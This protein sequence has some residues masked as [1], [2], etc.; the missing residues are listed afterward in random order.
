VPV[1]KLLVVTARGGSAG[2]DVPVPERLTVWGLPLP[3]SLILRIPVMLP[4]L[5]GVTTTLIVQFFPGAT[6]LPQLCVWVKGLLVVIPSIK[7]GQFPVFFSV[8]TFGLLE[9]PTG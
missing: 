3:L 8:T 5:E 6:V 2:P 7:S 9:V 1:G 4:V